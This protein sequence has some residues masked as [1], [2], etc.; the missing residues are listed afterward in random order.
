MKKINRF[1]GRC[2]AAVCTAAV[3]LSAFGISASADNTDPFDPEYVFD[4]ADLDFDSIGSTIEK[5]RKNDLSPDWGGGGASIAAAVFRGNE[6]MY[7]GYFGETDMENHIP[8]DESSV[9]EWGSISKTMIWVSVMQLWEQG[10]IDLDADIRTY[11]P[12]GFLRY[13]SYDEP[14]T[15]THLMNHCGGWCETTYSIQTDSESDIPTLEE[16]VSSTEPAQIYRPGE[17]TIYSN[18][19]AALAAYIVERVSGTDYTEYVHKNILEPLGMEHTAVSANHRDNEWVRTQRE[20]LKSYEYKTFPEEKYKLMGSR[21]AYIKLYPAGSATGT[22]GDLAKYAMAF[23]DD[24]A[25]LFRNKETQD[26]LFSGAMDISMFSYGFYAT[27]YTVRTFGHNGGTV[28]CVSK[29]LFDP[30]SKVGLVILTNEPAGNYVYSVL[31]SLIFEEFRERIKYMSMLSKGETVVLDGY[32]TLSQSNN[33]GLMKFYSF[34]N[35]VPGEAVPNIYRIDGKLYQL[36]SYGTPAPIIEKTYRDGGTGLVIGSAELIREKM[37]V[38]KLCVLTVYFMLAAG[39]F[40]ILLVK[41]KMKKAGKLRGYT[42]IAVITAGQAAKVVSVIFLMVSASFAFTEIYGLPK[43]VG[44]SA[45]V[46]QIICIALYAAAALISAY[47]LAAKKPSGLGK[48]RYGLGIV[49][50]A[51]AVFAAV[52]FEMYKFWGC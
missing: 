32:Y 6:V 22:L 35:T 52:Y 10:K 18:W 16:A 42:G 27:D 43:A 5:I 40:F 20:K 2:A 25:P 3:A 45:G 11:L 37:Y 48:L 44:V 19:G 13:L 41:L 33:A 36:D 39:A 12:E 31:P 47:A 51:A 7:E 50:N 8:A 46:V 23:V 28:S 17:V 26:K 4:P 24:S 30:D 49:C 34:L 29:M 38:P 15:M 21:M 1:F 14:V 9:Y